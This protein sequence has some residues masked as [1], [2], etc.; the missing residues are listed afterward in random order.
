MVLA[1]DCQVSRPD[2]LVEGYQ[3]ERLLQRAILELKQDQRLVLVL[4][5]IENLSYEDIS[6]I[7]GLPV[8]TVKSRLHRARMRV[9]E[10]LA[11]NAR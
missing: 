11:E 2:E 5:D 1:E 8:G 4:R 3:T 10:A 9:R 7:T 6:E